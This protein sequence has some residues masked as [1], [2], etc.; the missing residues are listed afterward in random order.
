MIDDGDNVILSDDLRTR[1]YMTAGD[2]GSI[3]IASG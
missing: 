1:L 2:Y 3:D